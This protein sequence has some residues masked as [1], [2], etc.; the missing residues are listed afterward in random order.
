MYQL[1]FRGAPRAPGEDG[2]ESAR[3]LPTGLE[4]SR[5]GHRTRPL[6]LQRS[7]FEG[8]AWAAATAKAPSE[9]HS[10]PREVESGPRTHFLGEFNTLYIMPPFPPRGDAPRSN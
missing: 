6:L 2:V 5:A 9:L 1:Q 10:R 4:G 8:R 7:S 3:G